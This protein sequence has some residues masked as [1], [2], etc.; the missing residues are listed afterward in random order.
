MKTFVNTGWH[1]KTFTTVDDPLLKIIE[2]DNGISWTLK[3]YVGENLIDVINLECPRGHKLDDDI[4]K[5]SVY[6]EEENYLGSVEERVKEAI[7]L[8]DINFKNYLS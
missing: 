1:S 6:D 2:V 8:L 4:L 7:N 5:L 3:F